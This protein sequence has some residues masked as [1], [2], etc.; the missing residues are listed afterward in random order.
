VNRTENIIL[1]ISSGAGPALLAAALF[2][3][4][5]PLAKLLLR[6][7]GPWMLAGIL[8][9]GS[10][11]GL[12]V[13]RI[14][15]SASGLGG[16]QPRLRGR[17]WLWLGASIFSGGI[18]APVLLMMGLALSSASTA[19]L[20][21]N[22]EG[23]FTALLARFVF[24]EHLGRRIAAGMASIVAGGA[25][26]AAGGDPMA[27]GGAG[28]AAI[29]AACLAWATDNNLTRKVSGTDP[30]FIAMLKGGVA[31]ATNVALARWL[32][33]PW[34]APGT[35]TAALAVGFLG[36]GV[37]LVLFVVALG[38][39]GVART[40]AYFSLAPFF[41]G[42]IAVLVLRD[43]VT[44]SLV[45]A[46]ALM[47]LGVW[48]HLTERHEHEH[49]HQG[50]LRGRRH[51]PEEEDRDEERDTPSRGRGRAPWRHSHPHYPDTEHR[52]DH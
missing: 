36:Y 47:A 10:G 16:S 41:G 1:A 27:R 7:M 31:G 39:I 15:R 11:L 2:G 29:A 50:R 5:T 8:Y 45:A 17:G 13:L 9:L 28:A 26:L 34:P 49:E 23:V 6:D 19:A 37:S 44:I 42:A 46:G 12:G 20:L 3:A 18:V 38:G 33:S 25:V 22:L 24:R 35:L 48:L 14:V 4:S 51:A 32:G 40:A 43:P 30:V 52:H 21:L